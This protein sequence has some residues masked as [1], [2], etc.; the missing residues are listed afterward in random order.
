MIQEVIKPHLELRTLYPD[1]INTFRI[2]TYLWKGEVCHWPLTLRIG[3]GG[4][5]LDNA[6]AG[7]MFINVSEDGWLNDKAFTEFQKVYTEHPDTHVKYEGYRISFVQELLDAAKRMH[8]NAPQLGVISWDLTVDEDGGIVLIEVNTQSQTIWFP[9][10][11]SGEPAFG[12]NTE[13]VL[14]YIKAQ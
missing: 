13:A 10:M 8:L 4:S 9:Q 5:F 12:D 7:G 6:H 3:Q 14:Q 2:V 11:A 1:A